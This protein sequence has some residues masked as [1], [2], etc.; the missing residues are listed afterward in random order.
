MIADFLDGRKAGPLAP[1]RGL[2][3]LG[4]RRPLRYPR[5]MKI[6]SAAALCLLALPASATN[7]EDAYMMRGLHLPLIQISGRAPAVVP[8]APVATTPGN[9]T[10]EQLAD[11]FA[12]AERLTNEGIAFP[13]LSG[14]RWSCRRVVDLVSPG[15]HRRMSV[16]TT[17][18]TFSPRD[19]GVRRQSAN[20][21]PSPGANLFA[22]VPGNG[23]VGAALD[24][25]GRAYAD[26]TIRF[27]RQAPGNAWVLLVQATV[28]GENVST[29]SICRAVPGS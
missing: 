10:P 2:W 26:E 12:K 5:G 8:P 25:S 28:V 27:A 1:A 29:Y 14:S 11:A 20:G 16:T 15:E 3:A 7:W 24:A 13:I 23:Y 18:Y 21:N 9:E 17:E 22:F 19:R 6:P 4:G